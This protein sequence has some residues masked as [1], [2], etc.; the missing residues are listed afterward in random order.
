M[1]K[2]MLLVQLQL[3]EQP[4]DDLEAGGAYVVVQ[5]GEVARVDGDGLLGLD[6]PLL[7]ALRMVLTNKRQELTNGK[8]VRMVSVRFDDVSD[9]VASL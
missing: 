4:K 1:H 9:I 2:K 6:S 3:V 5:D 8:S 7:K